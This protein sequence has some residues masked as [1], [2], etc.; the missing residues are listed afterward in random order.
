MVGETA[1]HVFVRSKIRAM[2]QE[3][4]T[5][6]AIINCAKAETTPAQTDLW[7]NKTL[8]YSVVNKKQWM[9]RVAQTFHGNIKL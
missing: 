2:R 7:L 9:E 6:R 8:C 1:Q 3:R 4:G 5:I